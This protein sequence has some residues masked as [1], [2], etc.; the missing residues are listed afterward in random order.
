MK[1][2]AIKTGFITKPLIIDKSMSLYD[3]ASC[4]TFNEVIVTDKANPYVIGVRMRVNHDKIAEIELI[5]TTTGQWL[6]NADNYLEYSSKENWGPFPP[7]GAIPA[8]SWCAA[9]AASPAHPT[10]TC[11]GWRTAGC[12][13]CTR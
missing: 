11:S 7:T 1:P 2:A 10:R 13:T 9:P 5:T 8:P 3:D 12:A 6:F 4:Q